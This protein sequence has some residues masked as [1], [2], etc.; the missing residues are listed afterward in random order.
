V[1]LIAELRR[2]G[3]RVPV[4]VEPLLPG[5]TD[6]RENLAPLLEALAGA[7][8]RHVTA[9]YA[10]LRPGI[11][12]NLA[13]ALDASGLDGTLPAAYERG[14]M[15]EGKGLSPARYLPKGRRQRGYAALMAL[16]ADYGITVSV[17]GTTNPDFAPARTAPA[18]GR[19][20]LLTQFLQAST[21]LG[22]AV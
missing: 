21:G 15:L 17:S 9:S 19:P 3:V 7:G 18:T 2:R 20:S 8:V 12:D 4:G 11:A 6:T 13:R 5:L 16:A 14:P 22:A 10:F 1:R